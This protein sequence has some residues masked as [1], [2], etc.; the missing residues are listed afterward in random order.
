MNKLIKAVFVA[1]LT[2]LALSACKDSGSTGK[3]VTIWSDGSK[4]L[5]V[6][7]SRKVMRAVNPTPLCS[8]TLM[9]DL[10]GG[11][12]VVVDKGGPKTAKQGV[13]M[14][15]PGTIR[16]KDPKTGKIVVKKARATSF[17]SKDCGTWA[18]K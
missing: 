11:K 3:K 10:P 9:Y 4:T 1:V 17:H 15:G 6:Q 12:V 16:Y 18:S 8:W 5:G 13:K 7:N 2:V 14:W